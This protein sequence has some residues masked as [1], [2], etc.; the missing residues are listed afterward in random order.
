VRRVWDR[1]LVQRLGFHCEIDLG[2]DV[3]GVEGDVPE[4]GSDRV[5]VHSR[6]PE[7]DGR[8]VPDDVRADALAAD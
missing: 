1:A 2:V 7:M 6:A 4:P 8:R 5:D 3:G